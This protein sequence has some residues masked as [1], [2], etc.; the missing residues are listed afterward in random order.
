MTKLSYVY[1]SGDIQIRSFLVIPVNLP[2][3]LFINIKH[4]PSILFALVDLSSCPIS[5]ITGIY[6][7]LPYGAG[8]GQARLSALSVISPELIP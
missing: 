1:K 2:A 8:Y 6:C 5:S 3:V 7:I 4:R